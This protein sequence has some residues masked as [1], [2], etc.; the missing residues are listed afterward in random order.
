[1]HMDTHTGKNSKDT[2]VVEAFFAHLGE[3]YDRERQGA[4]I[5]LIAGDYNAKIGKRQDD[6]EQS[7]MGKWGQ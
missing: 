1:M 6:D 5:I 7:F 4:E 3:I 2:G